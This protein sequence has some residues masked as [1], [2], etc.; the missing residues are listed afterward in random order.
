M[1]RFVWKEEDQSHAIAYLPAVGIV[2]AGLLYALIRL[3]AI[4]QLPVFVMSMLLLFLPL[5]VTGGFHLDGY[6]D[7]KDALS[8]YADRKK[9][10]EI[11]KDPHIGA[12]AVVSFAK[13][14]L[15]FAGAVYLLTDHARQQEDRKSLC[16]FALLFILSRV[17]CGITSVLLK[18]SK[19]DGM[20]QNEVSKN[21]TPDLILLILQGV[22]AF[23]VMLALSRILALACA[24][25]LF[26]W[27]VFYRYQ[28]ERRFGGVSG[29]T[30]GYYVVVSELVMVVILAV[31]SYLLC[32]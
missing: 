10:L 31:C 32:I 1:P 28:C 14:A 17:G 5:L 7:V 11:L 30:A 3:D 9:S 25:G 19:P 2:L 26:A 22:A 24:T 21:H 12:F 29:D 8:A 13:T 6:L 27:S 18:S 23:A 20:L 15:L 4:L 16:L